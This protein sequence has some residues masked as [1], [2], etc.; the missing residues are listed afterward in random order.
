MENKVRVHFGV[1]ER[2]LGEAGA[3]AA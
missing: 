2:P 3:A 1:V